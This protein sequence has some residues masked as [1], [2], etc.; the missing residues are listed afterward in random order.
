MED[1]HTHLLSINGDDELSFF[2]VYDGHGSATVAQFAGEELHKRIFDQKE[3]S[4][5]PHPLRRKAF[6]K[7]NWS[8]HPIYIICSSSSFL[9]TF[10]FEIF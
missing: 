8:S 3:Y 6:M 2:G 1:A 7:G 9:G 4:K 5:C 10:F